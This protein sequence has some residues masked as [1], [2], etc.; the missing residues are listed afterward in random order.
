METAE[1]REPYES[2]GSRTDLG[3][4]GGE[5]PPGDSTTAVHPY[6]VGKRQQWVDSGHSFWKRGNSAVRWESE[7]PSAAR[8]APQ[9]RPQVRGGTPCPDLYALSIAFG[10][11]RFINALVSVSVPQLPLALTLRAAPRPPSSTPETARS[12]GRMI[13]IS[14]MNKSASGSSSGCADRSRR[15]DRR[16][17]RCLPWISATV[18]LPS[19]RPS[20]TSRRDTGAP[21]RD[22]SA[23]GPRCHA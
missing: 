8:A 23:L 11:S 22:Q 20:T 10:R 16:K 1:H 2:R 7:A 14:A 17:G 19:V 6:P 4:P 12:T 13:A 3:A 15:R 18:A 21:T 9:R 5:S